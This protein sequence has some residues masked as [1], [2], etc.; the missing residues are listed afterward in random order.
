MPTKKRRRD[1]AVPAALG[2]KIGHANARSLLDV[3]HFT[4]VPRDQVEIHVR[5]IVS[6]TLSVWASAYP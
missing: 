5:L 6:L 1:I 4:P 3:I 2:F